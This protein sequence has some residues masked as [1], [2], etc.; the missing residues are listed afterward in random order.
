MILRGDA[1][2]VIIGGAVLYTDHRRRKPVLAHSL[3][4]LPLKLVLACR[5][6]LLLK[7]LI[8]RRLFLSRWVLSWSAYFSEEE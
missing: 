8:M 4:Q 5:L 6:F 1:L 2:Q 3:S 7:L